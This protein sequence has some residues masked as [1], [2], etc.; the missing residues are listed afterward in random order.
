VT[1]RP[2]PCANYKLE[3][4]AGQLLVNAVTGKVEFTLQGR[5]S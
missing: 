1:A 3:F 4:F 5:G 2:N